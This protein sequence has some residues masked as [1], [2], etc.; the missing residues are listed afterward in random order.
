M[1]NY[2]NEKDRK[3][4][5]RRINKAY[6]SDTY[7]EARM[8]IDRIIHDLE[9]LN[10]SA[11]HSLAEGLEETLTLHRLGLKELFG[12]SFST[13]N[14]I[15]NLNSQLG[16]YLRNVKRWQSSDQRY[17]WVAC[18]LLEIELRMRKVSNYR[19]LNVMAMKI[20]AEI[21]KQKKQK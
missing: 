15:E 9:R 8:Q 20:Q 7:E 17:R 2:L 3:I 6:Q 16:R 21:E 12:K 11:A 19:H 14:I 5:K 13:T 10:L 1:L 4:Y 18:A